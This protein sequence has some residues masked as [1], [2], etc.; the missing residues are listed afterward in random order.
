MTHHPSIKCWLFKLHSV[1]HCS[2]SAL[3]CMLIDVLAFLFGAL[4]LLEDHINLILV[5]D[6]ILVRPPFLTRHIIGWI[7]FLF[8]WTCFTCYS[9]KPYQCSTNWAQTSWCQIVEWDLNCTLVR[10]GNDLSL[11]QLTPKLVPCPY[12]IWSVSIWNLYS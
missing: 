2:H 7:F 9:R 11:L 5:W 10:L 1:L 6:H 8:Q 4:L 12:Q 3:C